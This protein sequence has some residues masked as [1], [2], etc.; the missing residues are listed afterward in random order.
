MPETE[1]PF[2]PEEPALRLLASQRSISGNPF[3][4]QVVRLPLRPNP[5]GPIQFRQNKC[6]R[7]KI[8]NE[9]CF[10]NE[11]QGMN[12]NQKTAAPNRV[13]SEID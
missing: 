6:G 7:F 5:V 2:A 11:D 12:G 9:W 1:T 4:S 8:K 13:T 3:V 10:I